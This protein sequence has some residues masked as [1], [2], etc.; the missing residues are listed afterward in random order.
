MKLVAPLL[1]LLLIGSAMSII[2]TQ[3]ATVSQTTTAISTT[4]TK[5]SEPLVLFNGTAIMQSQPPPK[6]KI[7]Q[8]LGTNTMRFTQGGLQ[9]FRPDKSGNLTIPLPK[10]NVTG[11]VTD[12]VPAT[13]KNSTTTDYTYNDPQL[14]SDWFFTHKG[15]NYEILITGNALVPSFI[16]IPLGNPNGLKASVCDSL[17][18]NGIDKETGKPIIIPPCTR[19]CFGT[20][21]FDW[22]DVNTAKC[23]TITSFK[24]NNQTDILYLPVSG[25]FK[26]DPIALDGSGQC[27]SLLATA[28]CTITL[29][30]SNGNVV[31]L[32]SSTY[33][34]TD[35]PSTPSDGSHTF[36]QRYS[37]TV[38]H[39]IVREYSF[40]SVS[41]LS[42]DVITFTDSS[43]DDTSAIAYCV[44]GANTSTPFDPNVSLPARWDQGASNPNFSTTTANDFLITMGTD[45][46]ANNCMSATAG[47]TQIQNVCSGAP[48][49]P[50]DLG[51]Q[52]DVVSSTQSGVAVPTYNTF[53][54][55]T[56][57]ET[58]IEDAIQQAATVTQP[59]KI[60]TDNS[61]PSGTFALSGACSGTIASDG[62]AHNFTCTATTSTT[63]TV[64]AAGASTRYLFS[65][66]GNLPGVTTWTF[67][68]CA[69]GTC[70]E[71]DN[72]TYYQ[73]RNN[74]NFSAAAPY[75]WDNT[76]TVIV[77]GPFVGVGATVN[78][79]V[80]FMGGHSDVT[81]PG[82]WYDYNHPVSL[83]S[84]IADGSNK[85]W[86][87][88][89]PTSFTDTTGGNTDTVN[90]YLQL[91]NTY[92]ATP[93]TPP[94]WNGAKS[95]LATG[96]NLGTASSTICTIGALSGG[97]AASC[98]AYA[99]Y[100]LAVSLPGSFLISTST[101][102]GTAPTSF[103]QTTGGNT[104]NVNYNQVGV[105]TTYTSQGCSLSQIVSSV[106][107]TN[108]QE[109]CD[110]LQPYLTFT[111]TAS[112]SFTITPLSA[113]NV[114]RVTL[115]GAA[116]TFTFTS[117][118]L[119]FSGGPGIYIVDYFCY[120]NCGAI[121]SSTST[122]QTTTA[123][124][125]ASSSIALAVVGA[126]A[127]VGLISLA[128][129]SRAKRRR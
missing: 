85:Q 56:G 35:S 69:S 26:C 118:I 96:T 111:T 38:A 37:Y 54:S 61:G 31:C 78:S 40:T 120:R 53:N 24:Y 102:T 72:T 87:G 126:V 42:S 60:I 125:P 99:D 101:W 33:F 105:S 107:V 27:N 64:P 70:T 84:P 128:V 106:T 12:L 48:N 44:D 10:L 55:V 22:S 67:T 32:T 45:G 94:T 30:T 71:K 79:Q 100:N 28:S 90:Y 103:T 5:S 73:L 80:L 129:R 23:P 97:G 49:F 124:I 51:V 91:Q 15:Y 57:S 121:T 109:V 89:A 13:S 127:L 62:S 77:S 21:C 19:Q 46:N 36:T 43:N 58:N 82:F 47:Y 52:Y 14:P 39:I 86:T 115:G 123:G 3:A 17:S 29:S 65:D 74:Y 114:L 81:I 93:L 18:H 104:N 34:F 116:V 112:G 2:P 122:S 63:I 92:R 11:I 16:Q 59:I 117:G 25:N 95:I 68:T 113:T 76:F 7:G 8:D 6:G 119:T 9:F 110:S 41:A 75:T 1:L 50:F 66:G 98:T 20:M 4:T 108:V 88:K 83:Q